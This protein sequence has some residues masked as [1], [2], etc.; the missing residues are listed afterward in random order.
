MIYSNSLYSWF[1]IN[2]FDYAE[3]PECDGAKDSREEH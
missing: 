1:G 3:I 2:V